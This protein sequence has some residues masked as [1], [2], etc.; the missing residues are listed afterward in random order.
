[1]GIQLNFYPI[2]HVLGKRILANILALPLKRFQLNV[3][4]TFIE[5]ILPG[6]TKK[7]PTIVSSNTFENI[8]IFKEIM[9]QD[10]I[11]KVEYS[12]DTLCCSGDGSFYV[13]DALVKDMWKDEPEGLETVYKILDLLNS[14]TPEQL[15]YLFSDI[16]FSEVIKIANE[17]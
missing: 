15:D 6:L 8:I 4:N 16:E 5:I 7:I 2:S 3:E 10:F 13:F 12:F 11:K 14:S 17:K 9:T 1:M